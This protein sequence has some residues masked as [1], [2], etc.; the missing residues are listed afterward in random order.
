MQTTDASWNPASWQGRKALQQPQYADAAA[1]DRAVASLSRLPPLVVSWEIEALRERLAAAQRG[2]AFLLQ[3]GDC[4]ESF[5]DCE[6]DHIAKQLKVMLQVSLVL[7]HGPGVFIYASGYNKGSYTSCGFSIW[8]ESRPR[9]EEAI[10]RLR[11]YR[12]QPDPTLV[13]RNLMKLQ[14]EQ[15]YAIVV[16]TTRSR[17]YLYHNEDGRPKYVADYYVSSGKL[18]AQK[19]REGDMK[20]PIGVYHVT[21]SIPVKKLPDFYGSGAFPINYPNEWDRREGR[22]IPW[23]RTP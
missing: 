10:A 8:A 17:L 15:H 9:V 6:S 23:T 7:L 19:Q 14:P 1:L 4:A 18:G 5:E 13:P 11:A 12:E 2:E 20:T 22:D 3:G 16:D 21:S